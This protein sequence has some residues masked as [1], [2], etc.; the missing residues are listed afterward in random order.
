[1]CIDICLQVITAMILSPYTVV[2]GRKANEIRMGFRVVEKA[3]LAVVEPYAAAVG[4]C[5]H[6]TPVED[7]GMDAPARESTR[8][9]VR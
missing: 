2:D 9:L 1:L 5:A 3:A 4:G 8:A 7:E 6:G